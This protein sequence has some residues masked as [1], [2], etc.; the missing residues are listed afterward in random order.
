MIND[1]FGS[2]C[3]EDFQPLA[4]MLEDFIEAGD[5]AVVLRQFSVA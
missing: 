4:K 3:R 5:E 1:E 2:L